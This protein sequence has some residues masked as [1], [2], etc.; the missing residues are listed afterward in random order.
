MALADNVVEAGV[1]HLYERLAR[2]ENEDLPHVYEAS[3]GSGFLPPQRERTDRQR[4][5]PLAGRAHGRAAK[6]PKLL[7]HVAS[8]GGIHLSRCG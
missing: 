5:G 1:M 3:R 6:G 7:D 2:R 4:A 8:S